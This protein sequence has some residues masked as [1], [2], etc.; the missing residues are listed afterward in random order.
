[1]RVIFN[2]GNLNEMERIGIKE[3]SERVSQI[4]RE[5][6]ILD[7]RTPEEFSAGRIPGRFWIWRLGRPGLAH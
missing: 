6:L 3:L 1:M 2:Q 7:V 5:D 4:G